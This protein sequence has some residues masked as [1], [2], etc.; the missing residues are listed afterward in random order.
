MSVSPAVAQV[1][2]G[3]VQQQQQ[4]AMLAAHAALGHLSE[5]AH[6]AKRVEELLFTVANETWQ[7]AP[8]R[9]AFVWWHDLAG[10]P[11]LKAVSGLA[12]LGEDSPMTAWLKR[13]H[14]LIHEQVQTDPVLFVESHLPAQLQA[15][16]QEWL[17]AWLLVLPIVG[18]GEQGSKLYGYLWLGFDDEPGEATVDYLRRACEA[19]GYCAWALTRQKRQW[20][21]KLLRQL[22]RWQWL[23]LAAALASLAIPVRLSALAPAEV[24]ALQAMVVAAP[25]DGV[26]KT[27]HVQPNQPVKT[28]ELL[29]S[30]DDTTLRNRREVASKQLAV[31]RA[32]A[33]AAQ[34][35][36]FESEQS[37]GE[38]A[39]LQGRVA[40]R[41]AELAYLDEQLKRVDIRAPRDGVAVFADV[42]EWQGK[43]VVT[44]ERVLQLAD[45]KDAGVLVWLPVADAI[46]LS[47]GARVRMFLHTQPLTPLE[48][49]LMQT[50][51]QS[52]LSP[53]G[54]ASYRIRAR[55]DDG[56]NGKSGPP[57]EARIGL[58]GTA[59]VYG[60][61]AP[62][63]YYLFRRPLAALR[64]WSGL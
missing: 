22:K 18:P 9:Q 50:S 63:G 62:L 2:S 14:R 35:K 54:V 12:Q 60:E 6:A 5:R 15:G 38:L 23:V 17:P 32:D 45:P 28:G 34:Q 41:T 24:I 52:S 19:Y 4:Q 25:M 26:V 56:Q 58:K 39:V 8:Y 55:F 46:N 43:P 37:K 1:V 47:E 20:H 13:A 33:M 29:L 16:W 42:N 57:A 64:E 11:R 59:K 40:E 53:E 3:Q 21:G 27:F 51:Y 44:G 48:S 61:Y 30:L 49:K 7:L 31:A 36:A 10:K